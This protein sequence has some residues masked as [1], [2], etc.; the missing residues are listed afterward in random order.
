[1][2]DVY[3]KIYLYNLFL[4][5]PLPFISRYGWYYEFINHVDLEKF[6]K[7]LQL[8]VGTHDFRSFCKLDPK[9][10][11]NDEDKNTIRTIDLIKIKKLP[12]YKCLQITVKGKSFL[13]F[14]IRRMIG[15]AL[16]VAR[17][18]NLSVNYIKGLLDNP[19]SKQTL[20]KAKGQGLIL[21]KIVYKSKETFN[22]NDLEK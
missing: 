3:Y 4:E 15:Y 16:D 7:I 5:K 11:P 6:N 17:R 19:N 9:E 14:Q 20:V 1:M 2:I 10:N 12:Q 8:Y 22:D 13:R 18:K 21:R